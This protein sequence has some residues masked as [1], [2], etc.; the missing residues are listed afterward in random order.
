MGSSIHQ[1]IIKEIAISYNPKDI[2]R[3]S[4]IGDRIVS[5]CDRQELT[6]YFYVI[7]DP[8]TKD[9][10]NA[11]ST[12]GGYVYIYKKF[13]DM[14]DENQLAFVVAHEISH[15]VSRHSL[16]RMQGATGAGLA[17]LASIFVPGGNPE[18]TQGLQLGLGQVLMAYS[19]QDEFNADELA[20]KYTKALGYDA[21]AGIA[22]MEK[23]YAENKKDIRP[24][25]YFRTHPYTGER[26]AHMKKILQL[27]LAPEDY[28]NQM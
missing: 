10:L 18:F 7:D 2:T 16:K 22:V 15:I 20:I 9:E 24:I 12:P 27:P 25:S 3:I 13:L 17:M 19:R 14:L 28:A 26:I 5:V 23:L 4:T 1:A 11:F 8:K 21:R 6:Y